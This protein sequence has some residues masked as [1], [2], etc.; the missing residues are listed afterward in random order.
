MMETREGRDMADNEDHEAPPVSES[1]RRGPLARLALTRRVV[2]A[3]EPLEGAEV[4]ADVENPALPAAATSTPLLRTDLMIRALDLRV[5]IA[6]LPGSNASDLTSDEVLRDAV[7]MLLENPET[8]SIVV[9][10]DDRAMTCRIIDPFDRRDFVVYAKASDTERAA[11]PQGPVATVLRAYL[12]H[13]NPPWEPPPRIG[14]SSEQIDSMALQTAHNAL[15]TLQA[16]RKNTPEWREARLGLD[17]DD[18]DW[19]HNVAISVVLAQ[20]DTAAIVAALTER[21]GRTK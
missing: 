3:L 2:A 7:S 17:D 8:A 18:A 12:R 4:E 1:R 5:R 9:V 19:I 11:P 20:L 10:A 13:I 16:Q 15:V 6:L 14:R 21:A